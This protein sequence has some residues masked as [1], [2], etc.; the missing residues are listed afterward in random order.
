VQIDLD[1][2]KVFNSPPFNHAVGDAVL[3]HVVTIVRQKIRNRD[4]LYRIGGDD[5]AIVCP[6]LS[7]QEAQGMIARV[8]LSLTEKPVSSAGADGSNRQS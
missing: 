5:F 4:R 1:N 2:F 6:D 3:R 8:A 7:A